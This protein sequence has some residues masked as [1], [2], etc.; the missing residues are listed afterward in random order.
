MLDSIPALYP[1][2]ASELVR[3]NL[4]IMHVA[5]KA[6]VAAE[7][8]EKIRRALRM[9][10]RVS[11]DIIVENGESVFYRRENY[12]GWKGPGTVVGRDNKLVI[13]RHGGI[14]YRVPICHV[15]PLVGANKLINADNGEGNNSQEQENTENNNDEDELENSKEANVSNS[16]TENGN[17]EFESED[18]IS[19]SDENEGEENFMKKGVELPRISSTV[20]FKTK[21]EENWKTALILSK[22]G[23][24]TGKNKNYL[25]IH[26]GGEELPQGVHWD[27][28]VDVWRET[29]AIE[30]VVLFSKVDGL[31]DC[32]VEA[33]QVELENWKCNK[34][35]TRVKDVGQE[36]ISSRWVLTE[37]GVQGS[38]DYRLKARIVCR[39]YEEDSSGFR[40]DSPTLTKESMRLLSC[41]AMSKGWKCKS[42]DVRSAFLQGFEIDREIFMKPPSDA[43]EKGVLWKLLRC[44]Y[45]LNDAPRAWFKRVRYEFQKLGAVSSRYDEACFFFQAWRI[46]RRYDSNFC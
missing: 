33:K 28:F 30:N 20:S 40:T 29:E 31:K 46:S 39:G 6:Y 43:E 21:D 19:S 4:N 5:R 12:K 42:L 14:I 17:Q 3:N 18:E 8:S 26:V 15:M 10:L 22:G 45:G 25:N 13:V 27:K 44:P 16:E 11:N 9:K 34:V 41:L 7:S 1:C 35:F 37:K 38:E 32:V 23:K 2:E 36:R 24:A